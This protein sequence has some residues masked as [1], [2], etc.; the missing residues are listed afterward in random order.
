VGE[1]EEET[2]NADVLVAI[3]LGEALLMVSIG[4]HVSRGWSA[5]SDVSTVAARG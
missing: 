1:R 5:V 3:A 4:M 2:P